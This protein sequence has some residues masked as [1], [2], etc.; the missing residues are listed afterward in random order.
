VLVQLHGYWDDHSAWLYKS[1]LI[2]YAENFPL[3]VVLPDGANSWWSNF[4][5][6]LR[7]EDFV[8]QDLWAHV[9]ATL[10][11]RPHSRW[12]IGG[13]SMGGFGAI[14]LGLKHPDKYCSIAA[15]SSRIPSQ[16]S[17]FVWSEPRW[18]RAFQAELKADLDCYRWARQVDRAKLPRLGFDCGTED[19]LLEGNRKFHAYLQEIDLPH[20]YAEHPGGHT[21]DYWDRQ[22]QTA[23][24]QHAEA[25]GI[26][27]V[28]VS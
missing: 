27:P 28:V 2:R 20:S 14:R 25:L 19:G 16:N 8:V 1:N 23:L 21:W 12:A 15:H 6:S 26:Q 3:I 11:A 9:Q 22:V 4:G 24:R 13:L 5:Q 10:P 17:R 7:Y 18:S